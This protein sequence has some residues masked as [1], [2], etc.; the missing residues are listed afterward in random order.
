MY[1]VVCFKLVT[2]AEL[3][4]KVAADSSICA[5]FENSANENNVIF[6]EDAM[7][8]G[9]IVDESQVPRLSLKPISGVG[10]MSNAQTPCINFAL[11][12]SAIVGQFP[13]DDDVS[14]MY[15]EATSGIALIN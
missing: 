7:Y 5:D 1:N 13:V 9:I 10:K 12:K 8:I 15:R 11:Q 2:G 3:I 14:K 6:L 4:G